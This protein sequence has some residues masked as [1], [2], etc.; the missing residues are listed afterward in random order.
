MCVCVCVDVHMESP[1]GLLKLT[2]AQ[3]TKTWWTRSSVKASIEQKLCGTVW[4][5]SSRD[6]SERNKCPSKARRT[7]SR[8]SARGKN[9]TGSRPCLKTHQMSWDRKRKWAR[10]RPDR[11]VLL[12]S[13]KLRYES[14]RPRLLC[15]DWLAEA[16][17]PLLWLTPGGNAAFIVT[18]S[19]RPHCLKSDW[20]M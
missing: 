10:V 1:A 2:Q 11:K 12:L 17:P 3:I 18:D 16:V 14:Q 9:N 5:K 7:S 19:R 13:S 20:H 4:I 8:A 15:C 6:V